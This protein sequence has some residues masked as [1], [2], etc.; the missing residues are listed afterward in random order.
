MSQ[1]TSRLSDRLDGLVG[2]LSLPTRKAS[3]NS[4]CASFQL[5]MVFSVSPN[6]SANRISMK[7]HCAAALRCAHEDRFPMHCYNRTIGHGGNVVESHKDSWLLR[8][9]LEAHALTEM[10]F[11]DPGGIQL[12]DVVDDRSLR[13]LEYTD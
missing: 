5:L 11:R 12:Y 3:A 13:F 8:G 7:P 10:S 2:V 9:V 6:H 1:G 4:G